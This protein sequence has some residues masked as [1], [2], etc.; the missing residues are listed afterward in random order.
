LSGRG[1]VGAEPASAAPL[2]DRALLMLLAAITALGPVA[3]NLYLPALPAVREYFGASVA[4]VQA[5]FSVSLLT[6]AVG[7]LLWGPFADRYGRR[8]AV[9]GGLSV[10]LAGTA[11]CVA[12][13]SL[14]WLIAGRA[15]VAFGAASGLVVA[16][17]MVVDRFAADRVPRALAHLTMVAVLGNSLAPIIGGYLA[18]GFGWRGVFGA[19]FAAAAATAVLAWRRLPETRRQGGPP[20][21]GVEMLAV[22]RG[23]LHQ[24]QFL[25]CVAQSSA[26]Y[27]TFL[28]FIALAP[29]VL[30]S[31]LG[32]PPTEFGYWYLFIAGGYFLGNWLVTRSAARRGQHAMILA[33]VWLTVI[34]AVAALAFVAAGLLHPLWIFVPIGVLSVGQG[35][36]LPNVTAIAVGL[37]PQHAGVASSVLGFLQQIAGAISVQA[38]GVL[39]T[40]TAVPVLAFCAIVCVLALLL[41]WLFPRAEAGP[42]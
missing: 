17:A 12:A 25:N 18:A 13:P 42:R 10:L 14:G 20:P 29:Y 2:S 11:L 28:V 23:L 6:F 38:T 1:V 19:L 35:M 37:A 34:G 36:A 41:L 40:D 22:A 15:V 7:I 3:T 8:L 4:E 30:V 39:R 26:I 16:R 21:R 33:G 5:T 9:L 31:A 32:R 24:P 27:A